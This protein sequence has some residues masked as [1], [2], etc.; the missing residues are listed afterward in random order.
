[1]ERPSYLN[2]YRFD[3]DLFGVVIGGQ[4]ALDSKFFIGQM[5]TLEGAQE[6]LKSYGMDPGEPVASAELFGNFQEALQFIRRYFLKDGN[7]EGLDLKI[8]QSI[9][10]ISEPTELF[11]M[12]N[13][14][15][16]Y[17]EN[18]RL[19]AEVVLKVMHTILHADKDLRSNY[20]SIIQT[21]I[22]D[23]FYKHLSRN[24]E[25]QLFL[26]PPSVKEG[27]IPLVDFAT[28]SKKGRDSVIIKLLHKAEN[29][30]EELFDRI[31]V[32]FVTV[33]SLDTLRVI[34]YLVRHNIIIPHNIKPSRSF[35]TL[36]D[37]NQFRMK[38][39]NLLKDSIRTKLSEEE[40]VAKLEEELLKCR[41]EDIQNPQNPLSLKNY[42][43]I[44]FTCRQLIKYKN[45]FIGQFSQLRKMAKKELERLGPGE[46]GQDTS[47]DTGLATSILSLDTSLI[48]RDI[49]FFY[50]FE[51]QI[52]DEQ[53]EISNSVG[54]AGHAEYKKQQ[55]QFAAKRLFS[56]LLSPPQKS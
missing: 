43:S 49:R 26:G 11:L 18:E 38:Y 25:D 20:F 42:R 46:A 52:V 10:M 28:K 56:R 53:A 50:P 41:F 47:S 21:Q 40:F 34:N 45:P 44:Q 7:P 37:L 9:I 1:M 5:M 14:K 29:V 4:S 3:W 51:V 32:R 36:F 54:E 55:V 8:P 17:S 23:K 48:S 16:A 12:A 31:G 19:W 35:N 22:F 13:G 2:Q 39:L 15:N 33:K 30:A 27:G 24:E 6:F